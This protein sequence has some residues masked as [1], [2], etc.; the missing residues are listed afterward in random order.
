MFYFT[1][2]QDHQLALG[3]LS[4][5]RTHSAPKLHY[6]HPV[7]RQLPNPP[8]NVQEDSQS[9][10]SL[11]T[12]HLRPP[13]AAVTQLLPLER[14]GRTPESRAREVPPQTPSGTY[15][16]LPYGGTPQQ[17]R[18]L[19]AGL[20]SM[21]GNLAPLMRAPL[22]RWTMRPSC[23]GWTHTRSEHLPCCCMQ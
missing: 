12:A 18:V 4:T 7:Y 15:G 5:T 21:L 19:S 14:P 10:K 3:Y 16:L 1:C 23:C 17:V 13:D 20:R 8:Y 9:T 6:S 11:L 22:R 2:F